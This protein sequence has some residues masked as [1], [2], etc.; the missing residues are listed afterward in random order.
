MPSTRTPSPPDPGMLVPLADKIAF[1]GDPASYGAER[2]QAVEARAT[3]LSWVFLTDRHVYKLKK[4]VRRPLLDFR[5]LAARR[6]NCVL[7]LRLNRRLAEDVYLGVRSLRL[8]PAGTLCLDGE[9]R[10]VEALVHM[11]RL[12]E[13]LMLDHAL[14]H[15]GPERGDLDRVAERL[16]RFYVGLPPEPV[17]PRR[18]RAWLEAE[19]G[20]SRRALHRFGTALD[21]DRIDRVVG[22]LVDFLHARE[23]L[24]VDRLREG[25][26]VEG[27]GD[28]RPEHVSLEP[29]PKIID[30]LEFSRPHRIIDP[31][32]ELAHLALECAMLGAAAV[33]ERLQRGYE[34]TAGDRPPER[35]IVFYT[36]QRA[37]LRARLLA[38]HSLDPGAHAPAHWL[39]RAAGYLEVAL[40][41]S[42]ALA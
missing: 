5:T 25:R 23:A 41:W 6:R 2:A 13:T 12:P 10:A 28:L 7:E 32:D 24:L 26:L 21:T 39:A 18:R 22:R 34:A 29:E 31:A 37:L 38:L 8:S 11:R 36:T 14:R 3:H 15:G 35:L 42:E 4:P 27:H 16:A 33:G 30:C 17:T 40:S 9:G 1:L 19:I 20:L